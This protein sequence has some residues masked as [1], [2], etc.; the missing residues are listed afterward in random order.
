MLGEHVDFEEEFMMRLE[1]MERLVQR[2]RGRSHFRE[3]FRRQVI[4]V[5]VEGIAR[6]DAALNAV[7]AGSAP[8]TKARQALATAIRR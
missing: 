1:R 2:A 7:E 4:E 8:A 6:V 5:L 3:L